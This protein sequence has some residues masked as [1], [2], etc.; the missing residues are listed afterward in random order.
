MPHNPG[1][2]RLAIPV[3]AIAALVAPAFS[4]DGLAEPITIA[5]T[6]VEFGIYQQN[7]PSHLRFYVKYED[8]QGPGG[9][10]PGPQ[11]L[12][13]VFTPGGIPAT[14]RATAASD[15]QF[16]PF[17][18]LLTNDR[19]DQ[20]EFTYE[21]PDSRFGGAF[22]FVPKDTTIFP[23]DWD[24]FTVTSLSFTLNE[25]SF[26]RT[27]PLELP[28]AGVL[29]P[30]VVRGVFEVHGTPSP[31][32][33]PSTMILVGLGAAGLIGRKVR[34]RGD[35]TPAERDSSAARGTEC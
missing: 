20:I 24:L 29:F 16:G 32:P 13:T 6:P 34:Y 9:A 33:E 25:F 7:F 2:W 4:T 1:T 31:V 19:P 11:V 18:S 10:V 8:T 14:V 5:S 21:P 17:V 23:I 35:K 30:V 27:R 12:N 22:A 3:F 15:V 26:D 28:G